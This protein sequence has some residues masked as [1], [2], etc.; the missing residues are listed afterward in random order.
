M[1]EAPSAGPPIATVRPSTS[2]PSRIVTLVAVLVPPLG[3]LA[4]MGL[5]W[6]AAVRPVDVVLLVALYTACGLGITVGFHRLFSHRAFKAHPRSGRARDPGFDDD[7]GSRDP[8][9]DR[10]PQA[11]RAVRPRGRPPLAARRATA[12]SAAVRLLAR[13]HGLAVTTKGMERGEQLRPRPLDD[14]AIRL[15]DRLYLLWVVLRSP[16]R[17]PIGYAVD[18]TLGGRPDRAWS[19][20]AWSGSSCST[21]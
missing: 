4:A 6:G 7:P 21:T 17:S 2:I 19:G 13:A 9:G 20:A 14:R 5:L 15:I 16:S 11:P 10:P 12:C 3:V 1:T 18:P 8:V